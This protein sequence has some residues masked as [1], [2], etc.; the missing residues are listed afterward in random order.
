MILEKI[1]KRI[2]QIKNEVLIV[3]DDMVADMLSNEKLIYLLEEENQIFLLSL[4]HY[5]IL[6]LSKILDYIYDKIVGEKLQSDINRRAT[7]ICL[8]MSGKSDKHEHLAGEE[9]SPAIR[10]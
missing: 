5:V 7:K 2:I 9:I 3:F 6:L 10:S 4:S 8:L 1:L